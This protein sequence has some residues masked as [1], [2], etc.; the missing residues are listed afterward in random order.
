MRTF[1]THAHLNDEDFA[2]ILD[3]VVAEAVAAGVRRTLV[4]GI[5]RASSE[6][7]VEIASRHESLYAAVGIQPNVCGP[8]TE[9][10]WA[11]ITAMLDRPKVVALGETGLDGY[12]QTV[13]MEVQRVW[14][15]RH[16][17]L[18]QD[19][20][21]P[22]IVHLRDSA[23][24]IREMLE[25]AARRG[26]LRG[27]MHSFTGDEAYAARCVELGLY[28]SFAGMATFKKSD[29]LRRVAATVPEDRLLIETDAP[30]LSPEPHRGKKPNRP[31]WVVHTLAKLAEVRGV[32]PE[33]LAEATYRNACR[34]FGLDADA[35]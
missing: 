32:R 18:S 5:D 3:D 25:E 8:A 17:R 33:S 26:P 23:E 12:W 7:A 29:D 2:S 24:P 14:F 35:E 6:R 19:R 21:V 20:D 34:L 1:D 13:P 4:I 31:A 30:Y 28:I 15:D 22:F 27:V 10:D 16:L 11:A 9:E